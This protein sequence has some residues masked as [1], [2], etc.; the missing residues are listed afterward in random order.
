MEQLH[1]RKCKKSYEMQSQQGK[2]FVCIWMTTFYFWVAQANKCF[3][4]G[5][6]GKYWSLCH[7]PCLI[8]FDLGFW[9]HLQVMSYD[10]A[11]QVT[12]FEAVFD[13]RKQDFLVP[14]SFRTSV[15]CSHLPVSKW[16]IL[17]RK[18]L[19]ELNKSLTR[20]AFTSLSYIFRKPQSRGRDGNC[21]WRRACFWKG[22][23]TRKKLSYLFQPD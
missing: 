3:C 23:T 17:F 1:I 6:V 19:Q 14:G 2:K 10:W 12:A 8:L 15:V 11:Y 21:F 7:Q 22:P 16:C 4:Y 5:P 9:E 18:L 20:T 13:S